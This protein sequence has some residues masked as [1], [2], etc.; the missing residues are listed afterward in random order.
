MGDWTNA[1]RVSGTVT[2][3]RRRKF[4]GLPTTVGSV[5]EKEVDFV[6]V[7]VPPGAGNSARVL[8]F[9]LAW[10]QNWARYPT[11][12]LDLVVFDPAG[13]RYTDESLQGLNSP[14]RIEIK[15]PLVVPGRWTAAITGVT[16]HST[17]HHDR[18]QDRP[19]KE[20]YTFR[21]EADG[22]RLKPAN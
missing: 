2:I 21:A 19:P 1:G 7:E 15:G 6:E 16:I 3:T 12:D 20:I 11:N 10:K 17:R 14:E 13:K 8:V 22:K 4:D 18:R 9:E 5:G